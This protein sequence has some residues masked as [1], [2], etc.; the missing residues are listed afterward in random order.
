LN[1]VVFLDEDFTYP[2]TS[3]QSPYLTEHESDIE[4][5]E[6]SLLVFE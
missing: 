3:E 5:G 4:Y 2:S 1:S 6:F